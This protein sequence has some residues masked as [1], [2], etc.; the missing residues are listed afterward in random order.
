MPLRLRQYVMHKILITA[1]LL[2]TLSCA[3]AMC[4]INTI[5]GEVKLIGN[6]SFMNVLT[7]TLQ[8]YILFLYIREFYKMNFFFGSSFFCLYVLH[9]SQN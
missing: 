6:Y 7:L 2:T 3:F 5:E 8:I 1:K 4:E 9:H